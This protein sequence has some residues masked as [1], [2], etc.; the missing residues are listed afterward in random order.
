MTVPGR[1]SNEI[2]SKIHDARSVSDLEAVLYETQILRSRDLLEVATSLQ[3]TSAALRGLAELTRC[4]VETAWRL[5]EAH[6]I[7]R[8]TSAQVSEDPG[9]EVDVRLSELRK[10]LADWIYEYP[11]P[12]MEILRQRVLATLEGGLRDVPTKE[13]WWTVAAIGYRAATIYDLADSLADRDDEIGGAAMTAIASLGVPDERRRRFR[14]LVAQRVSFGLNHGAIYALQEQAGAA[15]I[16]LVISLYRQAESADTPV[17]RNQLA[18]LTNILTRLAEQVPDDH[19]TQE[20]VWQIVRTHWNIVSMSSE[21]AAR[22]NIETTITDYA[23]AIVRSRVGDENRERNVRDIRYDRMSDLVKP[24]QLLGWNAVDHDGISP[25]LKADACLDTSITGNYVTTEYRL[26]VN[27][28]ETA[29]CLPLRDALTWIEAAVFNESDP[30]AAAEV[31]RA[32][33]CMQLDALPDRLLDLI[34]TEYDSTS[35]DGSGPLALHATAIQLAASSESREAFEAVLEFGFTHDGEVLFSTADALADLADARLLV[36]DNDIVRLLF[37][38]AINSATKRHREAAIY[39]ICALAQRERIKES[40]IDQ[41][42]KLAYDET[43]KEYFRCKALEAMGFVP[44]FIPDM[45]SE[46]LLRLAAESNEIGWRVLEVFARRSGPN[47]KNEE[48]VAGRLH[49]TRNDGDWILADVDVNAWQAFLIGVLYR[50][51]PTAMAQP[52]AFVIKHGSSEATRQ[53]HDSIVE[54]GLETPEAVVDAVVARIQ[55]RTSSSSAETELFEILGGVSPRRL[56][57]ETSR[58]NWGDWIMDGRVALCQAVGDAVRTDPSIQTEAALALEAFTRD[59]AYAVRRVAFRGLR[60]IHPDLFVGLWSS[61]LGASDIEVRK[62]AAEGARW[63]PEATVSDDDFRSCGLTFDTELSVR[64]IA[65]SALRERYEAAIA[66]QYL[67]KVL[68]V[69]GSKDN[70]VMDAYRYGRALEKVGDDATRRSLR[71]LPTSRKLPTH[72]RYWRE[73]MS[74]R[75]GKQWTKKTDEWPDPWTAEPGS[76]ERMEGQIVLD[77]GQAFD[78]KMNLWIRNRTSPSKLG[79]W[80][81]IVELVDSDNWHNLMNSD[82]VTLRVK[83][84]RTA[85]ALISRQFSTSSHDRRLT[86]H[87]T[88]RYPESTHNPVSNLLDDILLELQAVDATAADTDS[89]TVATGIQRLTQRIETAY[90]SSDA[91]DQRQLCQHAALITSEIANHVAEGTAVSLV[92]WRVC[93]RVLDT[94]QLTLRLSADDF[95][96]FHELA[97]SD[98]EQFSNRLLEQLS[99]TVDSAIDS[100]STTKSVKNR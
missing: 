19:R 59:P 91:W 23:S 47:S 11:Q 72:V 40:W 84:R 7:P 28:W 86:I 78:A 83:N 35:K 26:K 12:S 57:E 39:A 20:Q 96:S 64:R 34:R 81:G 48:F 74:K 67:E 69:D 61:W 17:A 30:S 45:H 97:K 49:L 88:A 9:I 6:L 58:I 76:I 46:Q 87:G 3:L 95:E 93:Q 94:G 42:M 82:Y 100:E 50:A 15:E 54:R 36:G 1:L 16:E 5:I 4:D 89:A 24:A 99:P 92:L 52:M 2:W 80:G 56:V 18:V 73:R 43:L 51:N 13:A 68:R 79:E 21:P 75:I 60:T 65:K 90:S 77:D 22:C 37:D 66:A 38:N 25:L 33:A 44:S 63:L 53:V 71:S 41:L 8:C 55:V 70:D 62:L 98:P 27:A 32:C 85:R 31:M 10:T 29:F 14:E